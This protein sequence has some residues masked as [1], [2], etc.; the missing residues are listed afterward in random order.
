MTNII[1][2]NVP[3]RRAR[4]ADR[5]PALIGCFARHRRIVDDVFWLKENA[6]LLN[7]LECTGQSVTPQM[8]APLA[9]FY[10]GLAERLTFFPQYYRFL[11]SIGLD[12]EDLGMPGNR[13]EALCDWVARQDLAGAEL[14]DLQRAEARRLLSRRGV[15]CHADPGLDDRL[16]AFVERSATF[17][18]PNKKAAY[19]LTHIVFYLSEYGRRD[20]GLSPEALRS[21]EYAGIL[22]YLDQ[23]MD[24]LAEICV[25]LRQSGRVP[26]AL[27]E[28]AV[29]LHLRD[30]SVMQDNDA[31]LAD[32]YHEYLV[33]LWAVAMMG[34]DDSGAAVPTGRCVFAPARPRHSALRPISALLLSFEGARENDWETMRDAVMQSMPQ[35]AQTVVTA[36]ETSPLFAPF[37]EIFARSGAM[38]PVALH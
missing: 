37:F 5:I 12:L 25:A 3:P 15:V 38:P 21:L 16:R 2:L 13:I 33:S 9:D 11:L 30:H 35:E 22:A 1:S 34:H 27:W 31:S 23:N 24:L 14:S 4:L 29:R 28:D 10:D 19:E 32:G 26:E 36:A 6:E 20:P 8:L 18:L 17:A 7:I